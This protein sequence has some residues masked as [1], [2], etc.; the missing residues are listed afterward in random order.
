MNEI[1][2]LAVAVIILGAAM[3][4]PTVAIPTPTNDDVDEG[5]SLLTGEPVAGDDHKNVELVRLE[6]EPYKDGDN[7]DAHISVG[8]KNYDDR[9]Y[10]VEFDVSPI[11]D[12]GLKYGMQEDYIIVEPRSVDM[13]TIDWRD[14]SNK[15]EWFVDANVTYRVC[16]PVVIG[17]QCSDEVEA[18]YGG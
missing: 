7:Y 14:Q 13:E 4:I 12:K 8:F 3:S 15:E 11:D 2:A 10:R 6:V 17:K 18:D 1:R 5:G 16:S 9:P